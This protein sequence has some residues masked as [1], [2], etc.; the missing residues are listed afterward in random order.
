MTT[1][2]QT[3]TIS[4]ASDTYTAQT[5]QSY[6][7]HHIGIKTNGTATAGTLTIKARPPGGA[8]FEDI[9]DATSIDLTAPPSVQVSGAI[10]EL[11]LITAGVTGANQIH[12]TVTSEG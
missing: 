5:D 3:F 12:V 6:L 2:T 1:S 10:V 4:S 11:E 7:S 8:L 9:P